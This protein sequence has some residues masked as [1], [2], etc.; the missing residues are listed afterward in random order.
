MSDNDFLS[1]E[2]EQIG[3]ALTDAVLNFIDTN[4]T[5]LAIS[6]VTALTNATSNVLRKGFNVASDTTKKLNNHV[7]NKFSN[8]THKINKP[9]CKC[10]NNQCLDRMHK[11]NTIFKII[12]FSK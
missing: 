5:N 8:I 12:I 7:K 3:G 1:N 2:L 9:I 6:N 11:N 10:K 4:L